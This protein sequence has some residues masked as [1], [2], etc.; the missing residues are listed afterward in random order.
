MHI[1]QLL[2]C[3][4]FYFAVEI[5][6]RPTQQMWLENMS[7]TAS[8]SSIGR[9]SSFLLDDMMST[10]QPLQP[11]NAEQPRTFSVW[12]WRAVGLT[13]LLCLLIYN[14]YVTRSA[15]RIIKREAWQLVTVRR[16]FGKPD[17]TTVR[18]QG[19]GLL[20]GG[21]CWNRSLP[22][23]RL[24]K[25]TEE[26]MENTENDTENNKGDESGICHAPIVSGDMDELEQ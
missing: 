17:Q 12:L 16:R 5:A 19:R 10:L 8:F 14:L 15:K 20:K 22:A 24:P 25:I 2:L 23:D 3:L 1:V 6:L 18:P 11:D 4:T 9:D 7:K 13:L 26:D 21:I